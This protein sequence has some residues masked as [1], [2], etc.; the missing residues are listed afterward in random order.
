MRGKAVPELIRFAQDPTLDASTRKWVFQAL[1][2]I[3]GQNLPDDPSAW[4][5]WAAARPIQ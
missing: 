3:A 2:E 5:R 1:R 4:A